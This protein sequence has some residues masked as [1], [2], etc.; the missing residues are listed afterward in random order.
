MMKF[1]IL[2][3][4]AL[5]AVGSAAMTSVLQTG[6]QP[7]LVDSIEIRGRMNPEMVVTPGFG[8]DP[9]IEDT[10]RFGSRVEWPE[11]GATIFYTVEGQRRD[12]LTLA[13]VVEDEWYEL[14]PGLADGPILIKFLR[15]GAVAEGPRSGGPVRLSAAPN[16]LRTSSVVSLAVRRAG[17]LRVEVFDGTG[18]VVRVLWSGRAAPGSLAL[19]WDGAD[20]AGT[21]VGTG[22]YFIRAALDGARSLAKVVVTD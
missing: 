1:V 4:V 7:M 2:G 18:Q 19:K 16:P 21:R 13:E 14:P 12:P 3:A 15:S 10:F 9:G 8:G 22:V 17:E 6:D 11:R 5:A 20:S